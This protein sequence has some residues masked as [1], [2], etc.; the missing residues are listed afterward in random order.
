VDSRI[1]RSHVVSCL[2]CILISRHSDTLTHV[3]LVVAHLS[4]FD[5]VIPSF[6]WSRLIV[7]P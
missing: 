3:L 5:C 6:T 1:H 2:S 7:E 4:P